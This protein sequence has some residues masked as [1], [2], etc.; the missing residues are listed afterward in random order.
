MCST[1]SLIRYVVTLFFDDESE[2]GVEIRREVVCK[3][4]DDKV[5]DLD[6]NDLMENGFEEDR[7]GRERCVNGENCRE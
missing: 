4:G 2:I 6:G 5:T 3:F 1:E 7:E